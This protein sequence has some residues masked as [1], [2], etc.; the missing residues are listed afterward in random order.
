M[1]DKRKYQPDPRGRT[2]L[3]LTLT[4]GEGAL[5]TGDIE[6]RVS[7]TRGCD[8]RITFIL[9]PEI[10]VS[11]LHAEKTSPLPKPRLP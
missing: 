11:R 8:A 1:T 7:R 9:P 5:L 3:T 4:D 10:R 6:V 2:R